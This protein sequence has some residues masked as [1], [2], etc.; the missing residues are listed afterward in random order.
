MLKCRHKNTTVE[1]IKPGEAP[2]VLD[3]NYQYGGAV[4]IYKKVLGK[5]KKIQPET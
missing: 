5:V 1:K 4:T 3:T 2:R